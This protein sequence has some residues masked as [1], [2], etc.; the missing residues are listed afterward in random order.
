MA[1]DYEMQAL[2]AGARASLIMRRAAGGFPIKLANSLAAG[3]APIVFLGSEWGLRDG[4]NARVVELDNPVESLAVAMAQLGGD[5]DLA[6]RLGAG[7]RAHYLREH[8]PSV[9]ADRTEAL[10]RSVLQS[11]PE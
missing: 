7:A 2:I 5:G 1:S 10:L 6:E 3:T 8:L 4:V 9:V 11:G